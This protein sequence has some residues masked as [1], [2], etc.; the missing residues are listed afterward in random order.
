MPSKN[1]HHYV[2]IDESGDPG[3]LYRV[4]EQGTRVPTGASEYYILSAVCVDSKELYA[5]KNG[6]LEIRQKYKYRSEIKSTSIPLSMYEELLNLINELGIQ[7]YYRLVD[8]KT[9]TGKFAVNG[10]RKLHNI[11]DEYNIAK[12][13]HFALAKRQILNAD[14]VIDRAERRLWDGDFESFNEYL[15]KR[16]NTKTIQRI[17]YVTHVDSE[18]VNAMQLADLVS[19]AIKDAF[20]GR[21]T[22]LKKGIKKRY[23]YKIY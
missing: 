16:V 13:T 5:L 3:K 1:P 6:I 22:S 15:K 20:T 11:F 19:G 2:F 21:N 23:L 17:K 7:V 10:N 18:Y 9:Y 4:N 14:V 8:K 12:V